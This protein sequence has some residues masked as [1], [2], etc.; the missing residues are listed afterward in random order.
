MAQVIDCGT[1]LSIDQAETLLS[2]FQAALSSP[3][4]LA[5]NADQADYADRAGMQLLLA[6]KRSLASSGQSLNWLAVSPTLYECAD[7]LGVSACLDL[8]EISK[9]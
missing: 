5:I 6:L 7:L 1:R 9:E 3:E 8:P 2:Q 4:A